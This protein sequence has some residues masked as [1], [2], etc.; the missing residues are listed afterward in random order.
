VQ[1]TALREG[2]QPLGERTQPLRLRFRGHDAT[3]LEQRRRQVGK[4]QPLVSGIAAEAGPLRG[5]G[6]DVLLGE[7]RLLVG[8]R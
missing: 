6:H 1:V 8:D 7:L 2:H 5:R 3:V 4:Q